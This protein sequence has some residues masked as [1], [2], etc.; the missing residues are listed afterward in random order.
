MCS[1]EYFGEFDG[2]YDE[3]ADTYRVGVCEECRNDLGKTTVIVGSATFCSHK[4]AEKAFPTNEDEVEIVGGDM[5]YH[6][7]GEG[8]ALISACGDTNIV[9]KLTD[10]GRFFVCHNCGE[11]LSMQMEIMEGGEMKYMDVDTGKVYT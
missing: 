10:N 6:W 9:Y 1:D 3:W 4:C 8:E 2:G 7:H 11:V 5:Y